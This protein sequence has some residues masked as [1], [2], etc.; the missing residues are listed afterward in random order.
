MQSGSS[1]VRG[2]TR[3]HR[4]WR[5][6]PSSSDGTRSY[7]QRALNH[8]SDE[9]VDP[10]ARFEN[11]LD[12]PL[13]SDESRAIEIRVRSRPFES[14]TSSTPQG[15]LAE[16]PRSQ[17][18]LDMTS[19][20]STRPTKFRYPLKISCDRDHPQHRLM[21]EG[22]CVAHPTPTILRFTQNDN[23]DRTGA[24]PHHRP[25][26]DARHGAARAARSAR[27]GDSPTA[28]SRRLW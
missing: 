26:A 9:N 6:S 20:S 17:R 15:L 25:D 10:S 7:M 3:R 2:A 16:M 27:R 24:D 1:C 12:F 23:E 22:H 14:V 4:R 8:P 28:V 13:K 11:L 19:A 21:L 5:R 18:R